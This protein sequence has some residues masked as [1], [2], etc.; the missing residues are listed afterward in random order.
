MKIDVVIATYNRAKQIEETINNV[1]QF[2]QDINKIFII[3]N[4]SKDNTREVL[5]KFNSN[6]KIDITNS[7]ENL[8]APGGKNI[9]LKKSQADLIIVIDDDAIFFTED[10]INEV[11]RIFKNDNSLGIIQFKIV[12]FQEK[13]IQRYEFPGDN[14]EKYGDK[15]FYAGY[16]IGAGHA[17]R[18]KT[19]EEVGYYPDEFFYAHE[20]IDLSYKAIN[21][22]YTIKY[23]P[24]VGVYHKKDPG[25]RLPPKE[26]IKSMYKNRLVMSYKYFPFKYSLISNFLWF[27]KTLKD[28]KSI[29]IPLKAISE[30]LKSKNLLVKNTLSKNAIEY[31]KKYNGRLYR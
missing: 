11:K 22:N 28:S 20:E 15:E 29:M 30:F 26:V 13:R 17:I 24:I 19:L 21:G 10:P 27:L 4:N 25:G 31:I 23:C 1:L 5:E 12:N 7:D 18:K 8:G 3:N 6:S 16:F 9:G 14:P 2:E